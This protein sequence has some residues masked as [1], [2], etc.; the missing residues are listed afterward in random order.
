MSIFRK[1]K[2]IKPYEYPEVMEYVDAI[3]DSFWLHKEWN[4]ISDIQDFQVK[5]KPHEKNAI[6]NTL[7][8]IAQIEVSVKTF[9]GKLGDHFP[10]PEFHS[11]GFT[12]AESEVRHERAYSQLLEKL[13][14]NK[15]FDIIMENPVIEGRIDY[16]SK[17]LKNAGSDNKELY[18]L[19]LALFSLFIENV[20]LF[21]QFAIIKAFNKE[22][23]LLKD[24]DN[25]V[26][27]TQKEELV[28]A[29][30]GSYMINLVKKEYPEWFNE[31]FYA[32][33]EKAA[34]KAYTAEK[35]ILE[36][37][38]EEGELEFLPLEVLDAFIQHRFNESLELIGGNKVFEVDNDKLAKLEWFIEEIYAQTH[39]DF[40]YKRPT[41]YTKNSRSVTAND[42]Y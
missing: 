23:N 37:I 42:L 33:I 36:W 32:T 14:L 4:F 15:E 25:V 9:W 40:F 18:T 12:F 26:Q 24:I 19:T 3:N 11:V 13:G 27:A 5:L 39:A 30:L 1:R 34:K 20:S 35:K 38:F 17:Y 10:K 7:L 28:H 41:T 31:E 2:Q 21:S 29:L 8:A 22:R 6:K 16:L